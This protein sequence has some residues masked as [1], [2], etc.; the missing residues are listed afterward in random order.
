MEIT[1]ETIKQHYPAVWW[2]I[3]KVGFA[4]ARSDTDT[5]K[6]KPPATQISPEQAHINAQLG[7]DTATF[8]KYRHVGY[9]LV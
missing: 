3:Y 1:A 5:R 7:L 6:Q 8:L 2:S 4:E 9:R